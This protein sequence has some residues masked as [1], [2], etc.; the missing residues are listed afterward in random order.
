VVGLTARLLI[1]PVLQLSA[2]VAA[3]EVFAATALLIVLAS[4]FAIEQAGLSPELGAINSSS[5][6]TFV[7]LRPDSH[8]AV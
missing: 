7:R 4:S 1:R 6:M 5:C 8:G 2:G 3:D